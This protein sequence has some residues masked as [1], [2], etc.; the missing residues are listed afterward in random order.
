MSGLIRLQNGPSQWPDIKD[1]AHILW[2][3]SIHPEIS[4]LRD[5]L[6]GDFSYPSL[7]AKDLHTGIN[8]SRRAIIVR[9]HDNITIVFEG[10]G[11]DALVMNL[12]TN[13]WADAKGPNIWD[14]P[15]PVY[16]DGNRV[17]S[18]YRD[19]WHGMRASTLDAL[20]EAVKC[21]VAKGNAPKS[22]VVAGFS[23]GGGVST[24]AFMDIVH[25]VRTTWGSESP[26][27]C[28]WAKDEGFAS[29]IQHLT[30]AAVAA[31][32]QGFH[33]VLNNVYEHYSIRAWDFMHH[34]DITRHAHHPAF[35]SFRGYRYILPDAIV[36]HFG[37]EFGPVGHWI[38]G[39]LKA[40]QWMTEHGTDQVKS[41]YVYR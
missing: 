7:F 26:A 20:S 16:T 39:Y 25:H 6:A 36:R 41:E 12:W 31:G 13:L 34:N 15:F 23:M 5:T 3:A 24:M 28:D 11:S 33:T 4:P 18:F 14:I 37:A 22:I 38:L 9:Y 35:R 19:M 1:A 2:R 21:I 8:S 17:H 32:D 30:F 40:A 10:T 29:L 27:P